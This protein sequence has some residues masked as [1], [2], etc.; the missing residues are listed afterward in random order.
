MFT[1]PGLYAECISQEIPRIT[2]L[3]VCRRE[4]HDTGWYWTR[5]DHLILLVELKIVFSAWNVLFVSLMMT[6]LGKLLHLKL[7][8]RWY[9]TLTQ[10][11]KK[12]LYFSFSV[13]NLSASRSGRKFTFGIFTP[14]VEWLTDIKQCIFR[15][16]CNYVTGNQFSAINFKKI[17]LRIFR[18]QCSQDR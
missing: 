17:Q 7:L 12:K 16:E 1:H 15:L 18:S 8:C 2:N 9:S 11:T 5:A 3:L 14:F 13:D 4:C 10:I 6:S